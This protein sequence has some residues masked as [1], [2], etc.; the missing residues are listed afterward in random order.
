MVAKPTAQ[1]KVKQLLG[2]PEHWIPVWLQ[3]V[4]HSA[5]ATKAGGQRPRRDFE[6]IFFEGNGTTPFARDAKVV[7]RMTES[8]LLQEPAPTPG[9]KD[10]LMF[11][12]RMYGY[13]EDQ[14]D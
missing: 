11:L 8:G 4:G 5:E 10:E 12:A 2:V 14:D 13:P 3:L 9:R 7:Q 6:Q 1:E